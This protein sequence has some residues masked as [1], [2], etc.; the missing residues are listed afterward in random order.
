MN[1]KVKL[2]ILLSNLLILILI[3]KSIFHIDSISYE[4]RYKDNEFNIKE[5]HKT[6]TYI[7]IKAKDKI[8]PIRIYDKLKEKRV[9]NK[10]YYYK[11][12][13]HECLLPLIN[14]K[15]TI[16]MMCYNND[17]IYNYSTIS[18]NNKKLDEYIKTIKTYNI[19]KFKDNIDNT[20]SINTIKL[21][22]DNKIDNVVAITTYKGI[23]V[24]GKNINLF[25]TDIYNNKISTFID[26]YYIIADYENDYEFKYFYVVNLLN[27]EISKIKSK[28]E[29]SL[30]SYIQGIV[31]NKVYLYDKD[32]EKQYRIDIEKKEIEL[33]S[34]G[35]SVKYYKNKKWEA[36][37]KNK[38]NKELYFDNSTLDNDFTDYDYVIKSDDYYYL[39]D[40][41]DS[42]YDLY[43]VDKNNL[44]IRKFI[45]KVPTTKIHHKNNYI[46]YEYKNKL[47]YYSDATGIK[48]I[49]ENSEF[50]FNNT[51]KYYIY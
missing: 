50:E 17:V 20:E 49:L 18:G 22:K 1:K 51:I 27:K 5:T 30:D 44:E 38:A 4:I 8:Y 35:D 19:N 14:N 37:N 10:V 41:N 45:V 25:K 21:Y 43:R 39:F 16:D 31:D 42:E 48:T 26:H 36:I 34:N 9:I 13:T 3:C 23:N 2:I 40:K 46:Y 29:I 15:V 7:E 28:E 47:Y 12:E 11:D 24:S 32:N 6:H 33:I